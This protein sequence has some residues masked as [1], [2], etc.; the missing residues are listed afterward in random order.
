[1]Q[2][3]FC[4]YLTLFNARAMADGLH[5]H[6]NIRVSLASRIIFSFLSQHCGAMWWL[7]GSSIPMRL[8]ASPMVVWWVP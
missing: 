6:A 7:R 1:M 5:D 2:H 3:D 4:V 8:Q